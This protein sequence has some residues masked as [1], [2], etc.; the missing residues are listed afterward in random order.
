MGER[1]RDQWM[2]CMTQALDS[3]GVEP[4]LRQELTAAFYKTADFMR[5]Q[6]G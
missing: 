6:P 4:G 3:A 2:A 1:E 5:N